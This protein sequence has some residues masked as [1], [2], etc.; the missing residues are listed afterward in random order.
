M[1]ESSDM[2]NAYF[3]DEIIREILSRLPV[4]SLLQFRSVS[5][6]WKSLISDK[7]FIQSHYKIAETL[8]TRHRI[9]VPVYPLVSRIEGKKS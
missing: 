2:P 8:S 1:S 7:H 4:K 6:H 9:L 3:P 5:K